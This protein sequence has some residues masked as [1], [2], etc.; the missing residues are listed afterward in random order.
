MRRRSG[1]ESKHFN[2][3]EDSTERNERE[4]F[5]RLAEIT[6]LPFFYHGV[7]M[8]IHTYIHT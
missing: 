5:A 6:L 2:G 3:R 4:R 7:Q 8:Y 1:C